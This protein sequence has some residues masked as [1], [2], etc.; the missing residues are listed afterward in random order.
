MDVL[1][2]IGKRRSKVPK[3]QSP[4]ATYDRLTKY[5]SIIAYGNYE[6]V[7]NLGIVFQAC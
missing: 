4:T 5:V 2:K 3:V 6:Y 7:G 1:Q